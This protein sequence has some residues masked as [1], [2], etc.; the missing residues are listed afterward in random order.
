M[1]NKHS[2]DEPKRCSKE[3]QIHIS[4][5]ETRE[6]SVSEKTEM[7]VEKLAANKVEQDEQAENVSKTIHLEIV[8]KLFE[9]REKIII[10]LEDIKYGCK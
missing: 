6:S 9:L 2:I 8:T 10:S 7:I 5:P 4:R 1:Q 3:R